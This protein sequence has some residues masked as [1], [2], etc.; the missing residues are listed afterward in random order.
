MN[1]DMKN[2]EFD[3][4]K[5][6]EA[7]SEFIQTLCKQ[8]EEMGIHLTDELLEKILRTYEESKFNWLKELLEQVITQDGMTLQD[9]SE[10][11]LVQVMVDGNSKKEENN[12]VEPFLEMD[13]SYVM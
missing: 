6:L 10:T 7:N 3:M 4:E 8:L 12:E 5:I 1:H 11:S 13:S 9:L 2:I